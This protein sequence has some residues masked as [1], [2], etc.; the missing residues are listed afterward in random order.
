MTPYNPGTPQ[1]P[2]IPNES[3]DDFLMNFE[4]INSSFGVDH[5]AFGNT[6]TFATS[7][8]PCVCTSP[9]H[10][11]QSGNTVNIVH[12]CS[13]IGDVLVP[14]SING[15]PYTVTVIDANT[16]SMAVNA[17]TQ[18]PYFPNSGAF[19][20]P[21]FNYGFHKKNFFPDVL[22][23]GPNTSPPRGAPYSA[24]YSKS[25]EYIDPK[26]MIKKFAAQLWFQNNVGASFEK[27]LTD[28][29]IVS[30][31]NTNGKGVLTPW[32][33]K[34]NFG[35]LSLTTSS[36]T[37]DLPIPFVSTFFSIVGSILLPNPPALT[38]IGTQMNPNGLTQFQAR[39]ASNISS[40]KTVSAF[41]LAIGV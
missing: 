9:N 1:P 40:L 41:Y 15:G 35:E 25:Q 34:I 20:S 32:G 29:P 30:T 8:N 28:L 3:Q 31:S 38:R 18:A 2:D 5:V 37:F 26:D 33:I 16:F 13:L 6:V 36:Q 23:Q 11:L 22:S 14:W 27:Q 19:Y 39:Q 17:S 21:N 12:F 7:A 4:I 10:G 24:Y